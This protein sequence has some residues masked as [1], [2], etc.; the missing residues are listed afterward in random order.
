MKHDNSEYKKLTQYSVREIFL[1]GKYLYHTSDNDLI[2]IDTETDR[3]EYLKTGKRIYSLNEHYGK[4]LFSEQSNSMVYQ[5]NPDSLEVSEFHDAGHY[6]QILGDRIFYGD[7]DEIVSETIGG[8]D[9]IKHYT[10]YKGS[11]PFIL[12]RS[13][14]Y[15]YFSICDEGVDDS[16]EIHY[17]RSERIIYKLPISGGDAT[18]F[19]NKDNAYG[20]NVVDSMIYYIHGWAFH[21]INEDGSGDQLTEPFFYRY[22]RAADQISESIINQL[23]NKPNEQLEEMMHSTRNQDYAYDM[24]KNRAK[25]EKFTVG[26]CH[27]P[28]RLLYEKHNFRRHDGSRCWAYE[29]ADSTEAA[30]TAHRSLITQGMTEGEINEPGGTFVYCFLTPEEKK[31]K[32]KN[33]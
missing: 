18:L 13:E 28:S 27:H 23:I 2:R 32:K 24:W 6:Y 12:N 14:K 29:R 8:S 16:G 31:P 3:K 19:I 22:P 5:L 21:Q 17:I 4:L 30:T 10:G 7:D 15:L 25:P 11:A 33:W 26:L 1:I 20:L 9:I